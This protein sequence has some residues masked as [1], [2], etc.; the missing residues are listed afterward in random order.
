MLDHPP[1]LTKTNG[2]L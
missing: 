2:L 1:A